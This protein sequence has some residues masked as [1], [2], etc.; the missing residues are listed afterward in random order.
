M[1][2][3]MFSKGLQYLSVEK[4]AEKIAEMGF[5]G[6][7]LT[8]RE[9]GHIEPEEVKEKLQMALRIINKTGL[10]L[11]MLTT[12]IKHPKDKMAESIYKSASECGV[13]FLKLGYIPY[14]YGTYRENLEMMKKE[15]RDFE[16]LGKKYGICACHHIHSADFMTQSALV[17]DEILFDIDPDFVGAYIDPCH[18]VIEGG[19][20]GWLMGLD[21]LK[22]KIRLVAIK[23]FRWSKEPSRLEK[24]FSYP[25]F[26]S[27]EDG[28]VPWYQV[29]KILIQQGYEGILSFHME[30]THLSKEEELKNTIDDKKY[31]NKIVQRIRKGS[32][33]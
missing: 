25:S 15:A 4:A 28:T 17:L 10:D 18:M 22:E 16:S 32:R 2:S 13:K 23:D 1:K 6:V 9:G 33:K 24:G 11:S 31:L 19:L 12:D 26:V 8:V 29:M 20:Q 21:A 3:I 14:T 5:K 30:Y 27:L 7:D